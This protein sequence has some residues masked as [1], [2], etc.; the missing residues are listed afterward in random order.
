MT[1][2]QFYLAAENEV[3]RGDFV[4][5]ER[6]DTHEKLLTFSGIEI[7]RRIHANNAKAKWES[8]EDCKEI[9]P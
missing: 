4:T 2:W 7:H 8:H 5:L 9:E 3:K 1:S 6:S